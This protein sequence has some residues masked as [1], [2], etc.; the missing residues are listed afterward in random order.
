MNELQILNDKIKLKQT[1]INQ[2]KNPERKHTLLK[3]MARLR[4]QKQIRELMI[5]KDNI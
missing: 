5:N 3:Q 1:Q 4:I 2:E